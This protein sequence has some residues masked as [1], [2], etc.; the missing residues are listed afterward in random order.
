VL[1]TLDL[2]VFNQVTP[3]ASSDDAPLRLP[4]WPEGT[5]LILVTA[6]GYPHAIPVSAA[7]RAGDRRVLLGLARGRD[8]L[9]RLR[10]DPR[11]ALAIAAAGDVA[12]T[13]YG[14]ARILEA[15]LVAGVAAV[16]IIVEEI[17]DHGR[18][19]FVIESG[20]GWRWT[21]PEAEGRDADVR[22][23]LWRLVD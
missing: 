15:E 3:A 17:Q 14:T 6:G 7:V 13:A 18:P 11:A 4:H 9:A 23:A 2:R 21:D 1:I 5:V 12:V 16:E 19:T 8:S 22:R 20:V 10:R